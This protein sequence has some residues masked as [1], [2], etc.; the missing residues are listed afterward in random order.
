MGLVIEM[1]TWRQRV[2]DIL[3]SYPALECPKC[4]T[5]CQPVKIDAEGSVIHRCQGNGHRAMSW[6]IAQDGS[7]LRGL[8]G[9]N[10]YI[11]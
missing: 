10:P 11:L 1:S 3:A 7:M 6:R 9:R 4:E 5:L 2:T 8:T